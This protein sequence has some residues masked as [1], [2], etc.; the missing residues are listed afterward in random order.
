MSE[1]LKPC[2]VCGA[3]DWDCGD[4]WHVCRQCETRINSEFADRRASPWHPA[5]EAPPLKKDIVVLYEDGTTWREWLVN[6][7]SWF[8]SR[9]NGVTHWM[10]V[11][12][13]P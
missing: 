12:P 13:C 6:E 11:P 8:R 1:K 3:N 7:R 5:S 2:P 4:V 10:E 9:S